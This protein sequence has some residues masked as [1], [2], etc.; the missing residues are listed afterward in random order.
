MMVRLLKLLRLL[1]AIL[2]ILNYSSAKNIDF[3]KKIYRFVQFVVLAEDDESDEDLGDDLEDEDLG[4]SSNDTGEDEN[5][6]ESGT[7]EVNGE[8][9]QDNQNLSGGSVTWWVR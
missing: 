3:G 4:D 5:L 6:D 9:Q 7:E 8:N 1:I 2:V